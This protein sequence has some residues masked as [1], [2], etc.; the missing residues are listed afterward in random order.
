MLKKFNKPI[1]VR[2]KENILIKFSYNEEIGIYYEIVNN[3]KIIKRNTIINNSFKY[4]DISMDLDNNINIICQNE[5]GNI[6]LYKLI[7]NIWE[8]TKLFYINKVSITPI[9]IKKF[10]KENYYIFTLDSDTQ[11]I[12]SRNNLGEINRLY[13]DKNNIDIDFDILSGKRYSNL[14][15]NSSSFNMDKILIKIFDKNKKKWNNEQLIY[16]SKN[17]YIDKS[18]CLEGNK[19]YFLILINEENLKSVIYKNIDI[20]KNGLQKEIILFQNKEISSCLITNINSVLWAVWI[21]E[22]N[23]YASYSI[24]LGEDFSEPKIYRYINN[25]K[26]KKIGVLENNNIKETYFYEEN[27][28]IYLLLEDILKLNKFNFNI[29]HKNIDYNLEKLKIDYKSESLLKDV[30]YIV[31]DR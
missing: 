30:K 24:N 14:I 3:N 28:N 8:Y 26:I 21:S 1:I 31:R 25:E 16:V 5:V 13:Y 7:R 10:Y 9:K 11:S 12:Y 15:I 4:F 6:V 29:E 19:L 20:N 18:Y 17:T 27:E 2:A 22:N 23:I